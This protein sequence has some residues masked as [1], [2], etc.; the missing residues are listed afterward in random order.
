MIKIIIAIL[1][2]F[3]AAASAQTV[4]V[5]PM[6]NTN[7]ESTDYVSADCEL[8]AKQDT[9]T[10]NFSQ[11]SLYPK[12]R[13]SA[14][15][16]ELLKI[17]KEFKAAEATEMKGSCSAADMKKLRDGLEVA[18][19]RALL[20]YMTKVVVAM[21]TMCKSSTRDNYEALIRASLE[22][23]I[24]TCSVSVG[25]WTLSFTK[26]TDTRWVSNDGPNGVCGVVLITTL[27]RETKNNLW[28]YTQRKIVTN[29]QNSVAFCTIIEEGPVT[30]S[31]RNN[32]KKL[33]CDLVEPGAFF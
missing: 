7:S 14:A 31:W 1:L 11:V 19:N 13:P 12:K 30:Y 28:T 3:V 29:K 33:A 26:Q 5:Y 10:C 21:E 27:E 4:N 6:G 2:S 18:E 32:T 15:E 24:T 20:P 25:R 9:M 23:E 16:E 22:L 17:M 8:G